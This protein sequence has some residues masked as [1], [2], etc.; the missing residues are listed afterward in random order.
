[1]RMIQACLLVLFLTGCA[2]A[3]V[4]YGP[5]EQG[6]GELPADLRSSVQVNVDYELAPRVFEGSLEPPMVPVTDY[7][8]SGPGWRAFCGVILGPER[9]ELDIVQPIRVVR[10]LEEWAPIDGAVRRVVIIDLPVDA[11]H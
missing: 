10:T 4:E 5:A 2:S 6:A 8:S 3:P 7:T 9:P 11:K 1:M